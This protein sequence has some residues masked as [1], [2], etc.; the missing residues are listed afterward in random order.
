MSTWF[1]NARRRLKKDNKMTWTERGNGQDEDSD[2]DHEDDDDKDGVLDVTGDDDLS[3][4]E[5]L[6]GSEWAGKV[7]AMCSGCLIRWIRELINS[8]ILHT[9]SVKG[10]V[11]TLFQ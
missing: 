9:I 2:V 5:R 10:D 7:L 6:P 11:S 8:W 3:D 1:A 4:Q